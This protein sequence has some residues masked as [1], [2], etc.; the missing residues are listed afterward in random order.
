GVDPSRIMLLT[1]TNRAAREMLDR[2]AAV[3]GPAA[4]AVWGGTFHSICAR[5]LR[6]NASAAGYAPSF[7]I[8]DEE[9][10]KK[11]VG[12]EI[13]ALPGGGKDFPK[14]EIVLK[15][16]SDAANSGRSVE[17]VAA[18]LMSKTAGVDPEAFAR[19]AA[20]YAK[21]KKELDAMDF[22][23]LLCN[24]QNL[25]D[26]DERIRAMLQE[27]FLHVLV[28]EYQ[29][30]NTIQARITDAI[31]GLHRNIMAVGDDYQCIYTWRGAEIDNILGFPERWKGCKIVKLEKNY[32][33]V[34]GV[35]DAAN[36]VMKDVGGAFAKTLVP[37]RQ[38]QGLRP[39]LYAGGDGRDQAAAIASL[40][41]E[42]SALGCAFS[43]IAVLYRSHYQSIDVQMTLAKQNIP[44]R[45]TS[46]VGIFEQTHVKDALA[47]LRLLRDPADELSF[48]RLATLLPGV[49]DA[50]ARKAWS[51]TGR[52]F[53]AGSA[54]ERDAMSAVLCAK[55]RPLWSELAACFEPAAG[56]IASGEAGEAIEVFCNGFYAAHLK[57]EWDDES[58]TSRLEDL[59]ELAAQIA[60][61]P[62]G[63]DGFLEDVALLTN[64]DARRNDPGAD[65]VTL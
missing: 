20:G 15:A 23:D 26:R 48:A 3:A 63:L 45:L 2:T 53:R 17:A 19:V 24:T 30:T 12:E 62:G 9:D 61:A 46:G 60:S 28:D 52:I 10:Q 29:D 54:E 18:A 16:I 57:R 41:R 47:F 34:A 8:L 33:S 25:L 42:L 49:G 43:D 21:R 36:A 31:A 22:D 56:F 58:A 55:A 14:K 39:R 38:S 4:S 1:F 27:R 6:R 13:K 35:L 5:I 65:K 7:K 40:V 59:K 11:L 44:F 37:A 50:G 64:L 32:R 51:K